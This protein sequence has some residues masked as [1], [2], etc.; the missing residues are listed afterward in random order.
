MFTFVLFEFF[1]QLSRLAHVVGLDKVFEFLHEYIF[2]G[3]IKKGGT[4]GG[5]QCYLAIPLDKYIVE[6]V[7][8]LFLAGLTQATFDLGRH[9]FSLKRKAKMLLSG[10]VRTMNSRVI[11]AIFALL[12]FGIWLLVV[13]YKI[14][15]HSLVNLLQ[16]CHLLLLL[17]GIAIISSDV[18]GAMLGSL[19][20]PLIVGAALGLLVPATDGQL[21]H[22]Y[23]QNIYSFS[24]YLSLFH[25]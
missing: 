8:W 17:Q 21:A 25:V 4:W 3:G 14:C 10:H 11:D 24:L 15:L 12:H 1:N 6:L 22:E 7:L 5:I 18:R 20:F 23:N 2:V 13:Y 16:P 9:Y 19:T